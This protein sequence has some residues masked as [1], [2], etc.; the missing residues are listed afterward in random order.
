LP[1]ATEDSKTG[2]A[3][4]LL[5]QSV[6][7]DIPTNLAESESDALDFEGVQLES[8]YSVNNEFEGE[9]ATDG[10]VVALLRRRRG[11]RSGEGSHL[12]PILLEEA[13]EADNHV[14]DSNI[15]EGRDEVL[16]EKSL[17]KQCVNLVRKG[18]GVWLWPIVIQ[19]YELFTKAL[20]TFLNRCSRDGSYA[21]SSFS[22]IV[23][24]LIVVVSQF[25]TVLNIAAYEGIESGLTSAQAFQVFCQAIFAFLTSAIW[26]A[27]V[28]WFLQ[29]IGNVLI[30]SKLKSYWI[31]VRCELERTGKSD[32]LVNMFLIHIM[33][34]HMTKGETGFAYQN[35]EALQYL[36]ASNERGTYDGIVNI[37]LMERFLGW[38]KI[39]RLDFSTIPVLYA[40]VQADQSYTRDVVK[41]EQIDD[42]PYVKH[43]SHLI[44]PA[45][46]PIVA[47]AHD[48]SLGRRDPEVD[49]EVAKQLIELVFETAT[50][51]L[52]ELWP[53]T[54]DVNTTAR[55]NKFMDILRSSAQTCPSPLAVSPEDWDKF[56][57]VKFVSVIT[58]IPQKALLRIFH[59][60]H[61]QR[62]KYEMIDLIARGVQS[63]L[64]LYVPD[65]KK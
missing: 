6:V 33:R 14:L 5:D 64:K 11:S 24:I 59:I 15:V 12:S 29:S 13:W 20:L 56:Y 31:M 61:F 37:G 62:T 30:R 38:V 18:M 9:T 26:G 7:I 45:I 57:R 25:S 51:K 60:Q 16:D 54:S 21:W 63:D 35:I 49:V 1:A 39:E 23:F 42:N 2:G 22:L 28:Y 10:E 58:A 40:K 4:A 34:R 48:K 19:S 50:R 27:M 43:L 17:I 52:H 8:V 47:T 55:F 53:R 32:N 36:E 3:Q 44:L 41:A 46:V 65:S